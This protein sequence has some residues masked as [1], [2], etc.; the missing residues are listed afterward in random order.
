MNKNIKIHGEKCFNCGESPTYYK[1]TSMGVDCSDCKPGKACENCAEDAE[2]PHVVT[3]QATGCPFGH[4]ARH[5]SKSKALKL[6][7]DEQN[8]NRGK[9]ITW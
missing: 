7:R 8:K 4:V 1:D 6:W 5:T 2:F 9:K 3:H